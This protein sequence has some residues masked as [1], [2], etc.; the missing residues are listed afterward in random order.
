MRAAR[1]AFALLAIAC[2]GRN[3]A[4]T[5]LPTIAM[6]CRGAPLTAEV[7][8]DEMERSRG[9]MFRK[10]LERDRGMLFVFDFDHEASFWMKDT[11]LP[12]TIAFID[13]RGRI[14]NLAD[15]EPFDEETFHR[16]TAPVRY[17][18]EMNRGWF[19]EKGIGPGDVCELSYRRQP[20]RP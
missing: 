9:L 6:S 1:S 11:S 15:M 16:S 4:D 18:L 8:D 14:V 7:A 19:A 13:A 10:S 20:P 5:T 3:R 17:A 12:L 2:G